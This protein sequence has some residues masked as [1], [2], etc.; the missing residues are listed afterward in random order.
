MS[1]SYHTVSYDNSKY[2][3]AIIVEVWNKN[4]T[5]FT[6][7]EIVSFIPLKNLSLCTA[8]REI[9]RS[10]KANEMYVQLVSLPVK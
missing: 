2:N 8:A 1:I 10:L 9:I 4:S 3:I 5:K 7:M 6:L